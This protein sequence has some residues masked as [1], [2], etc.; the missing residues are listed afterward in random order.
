MVPAPTG[1]ISA[2]ALAAALRADSAVWPPTAWLGAEGRAL[3]RVVAAELDAA[4]TDE[5]S[6][7]SVGPETSRNGGDATAP[8]QAP[9][10]PVSSRIVGAPPPERAW[11]LGFV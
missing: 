11:D 6:S 5:A 7:S 1:G 8:A 9:S 2:Q 10:C 3:N 4:C